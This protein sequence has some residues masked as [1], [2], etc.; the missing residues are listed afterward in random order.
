MYAE[1]RQAY[2]QWQR[3]SR[4]KPAPRLLQGTIARFGKVLQKFPG[5]PQGY[6]ADFTLGRLYRRLHGETGKPS[7]LHLAGEHFKRV[8]TGYPAG[9]LTDDALYHLG[10]IHKSRQEFKAAAEVFKKIVREHPKGDQVG[11]ARK[12][13]DRLARRGGGSMVAVGGPGRAQV[14]LF[15]L[16]YENGKTA[17]WVRLRA[18]PLKKFSQKRLRHPDRILLDFKGGRWDEGLIGRIPLQGGL[19]KQLSVEP[20]AAA[21]ARL[22]VELAPG[23]KVRVSSQKSGSVLWLKIKVSG[24]NP[25]AAPALSLQAG[26]LPPA[27]VKRKIPVVVLDPGH[28]G[29]DEGAKSPGGLLEKSVNLDISR[30][31]KSILEKR[32]HYKVVMTRTGDSFVGLQDRGDFANKWDGDLFVSI[33]A[34]AAKR[35]SA[36][37]IETY[38]LGAGSS[39]RALETAERENGKLVGSVE[40]DEVQQILASLISTT[41][42]NDSARLASVVQKQLVGILSK[43]YS[44]V[45]NLGIKEGPFYVLHRT[46]MASI[47]VEV[48]FVTNK[49]EERRLRHPTYLY[50]LAESIAQGIHRFLLKKAPSI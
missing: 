13:L 38:F 27:K 1:A 32:Y 45:E 9:R 10:Q 3:Q 15:D 22:V 42:I 47:L 29:K 2:Y 28:G 8:V 17:A 7:H 20:G 41:K 31:V 6:K 40:D 16:E 25:V 14:R 5:S 23:K 44:K 48:G 43:K 26:P 37:G 39:D 18:E 34:N 12:E 30:R 21:G 11:S 36:K 24:D 33:H 50:W 46:N 35:K 19:I 4:Q 49:S